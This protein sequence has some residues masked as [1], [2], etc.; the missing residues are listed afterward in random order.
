MVQKVALIAKNLEIAVM[1]KQRWKQ[2]KVSSEGSAAFPG[3]RYAQGQGW[4]T[5]NVHIWVEWLRAHPAQCC[6]HLGRVTEGSLC[7]GAPN[8]SCSKC[9][10][11][12][13]NFPK[14]PEL[15]LWATRYSFL[16]RNK[17]TTFLN[18]YCEWVKSR[19]ASRQISFTALNSD[20]IDLFQILF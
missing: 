4:K 14:T 10:T 20:F 5:S 2:R 3:L 17:S 18:C 16:V 8:C 9:C 6:S 13:P 1:I 15:C 7:T 11:Q 12:L 19:S